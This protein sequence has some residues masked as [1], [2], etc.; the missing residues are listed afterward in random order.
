MAINTTAVV[1]TTYTNTIS[2]PDI[3]VFDTSRQAFGSQEGRD[4]RS[5]SLSEI[6]DRADQE[7][8]YDFARQ[9]SEAN[10]T[11]AE[12]ERLDDSPLKQ[13]KH[14]NIVLTSSHA[15]HTDDQDILGDYDADVPNSKPTTTKYKAIKLIDE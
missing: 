1:P 3:D 15:L 12:T 10:D 13:H 2:D 9:E 7:Q 5:S 4:N 11:E 14:Q 8:P 6:G